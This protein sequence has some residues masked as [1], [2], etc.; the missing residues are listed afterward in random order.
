MEH[1]DRRIRRIRSH[2]V[3]EETG[4]GLCLGARICVHLLNPF[5][6]GHDW[7]GTFAFATFRVESLLVDVMNLLGYRAALFGFGMFAQAF[8]QL[9]DL[10]ARFLGYVVEYAVA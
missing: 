8:Y 4:A 7:R 10:L 3:A 5:H 2:A 9:L 1:I 6:H